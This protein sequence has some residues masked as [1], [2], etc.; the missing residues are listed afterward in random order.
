MLLEKNRNRFS[1]DE[2]MMSMFCYFVFFYNL[3]V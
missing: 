2:L 3:C 1:N